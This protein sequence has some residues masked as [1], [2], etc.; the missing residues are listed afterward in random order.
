MISI[1]VPDPQMKDGTPHKLVEPTPYP[2]RRRKVQGTIVV[3]KRIL[4]FGIEMLATANRR[5]LFTDRRP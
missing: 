5:V 2:C 4:L 3:L 1:T